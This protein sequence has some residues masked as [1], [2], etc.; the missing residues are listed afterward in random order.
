MYLCL[1]FQVLSNS[2]AEALSMMKDPKKTIEFYRM[3]DKLFDCLNVS[4]LELGTCSRN[5][6]K[7]P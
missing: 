4:S 5:A 2:V 7:A 6:F 1:F 3:F